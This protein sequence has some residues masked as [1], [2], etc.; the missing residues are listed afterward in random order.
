[1]KE[2]NGLPK[3]LLRRDGSSVKKPALVEEDSDKFGHGG[4][5]ILRNPTEL[6][7]ADVGMVREIEIKE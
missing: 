4:C 1:M 7:H 3:L 5:V 6:T 2:A